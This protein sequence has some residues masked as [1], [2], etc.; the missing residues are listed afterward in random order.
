VP[1]LPEVETIARQLSLVL[2]KQK[3]VDLTIHDSK[4][5]V[6]SS[7]TLRNKQLLQVKRSGKE[8]LLVFADDLYL[9]IHL[10]MTGRLVWIA[11]RKRIDSSSI[12]LRKGSTDLRPKSIRA[13]F[14]FNNG[15]L[16]FEDVRRF[17]TFKLDFESI[18]GNWIDPTT[19]QFTVEVLTKLVENSKQQIKTWL[20]RQDKLVGIGNIYAS[21]ILFRS[22]VHPHRSAGSLKKEEIK[23]VHS[24][25]KYILHKAIKLNGTT[26]S[27][28]RDSEGETGAFQKFLAVYNREDEKC[29]RCKNKVICIR[30]GQRSTYFC[31][32]C[33][34]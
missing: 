12:L 7:E 13:E 3:L 29:R 4:L 17:G 16:F 18:Q 9:R 1:E 32:R 27:D 33:Q 21:E 34:E 15:T 30:Q 6:F 10:R 25:T 14:F 31:A 11:G 26:F 28:Y 5:R 22:G 23:N 24:A 2:K 8:V 20:L 19:E